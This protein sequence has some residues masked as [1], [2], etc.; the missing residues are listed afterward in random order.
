M[1]KIEELQLFHW[2][3]LPPTA[4]ELPSDQITVATGPN[5]S[6]KTTFLDALKVILGVVDLKQPPSAYIYNGAGESTRRARRAIVKATFAN[7]VAT[8]GVRAFARGGPGCDQAD[9]VTALCEVT[10]SIRR[11]AVLPGHRALAADDDPIV[12]IDALLT[13]VASSAWRKRDEWQDLM[14]DAG[15]SRA[16]LGVITVEQG[17]TARILEGS[18]AQLLRALLELTGK[19]ETADEFNETSRKLTQAMAD[20]ESAAAECDAQR[21]KLERLE[22]ACER[23]ALYLA[24]E[25]RRRDLEERWLPAARRVEAEEARAAAL[26]ARDQ[27]LAVAHDA[28]QRRAEIDDRKGPLVARQEDLR[29]AAE[30]VTAAV[31]ERRDAFGERSGAGREAQFRVRQLDER[32]AAARDALSGR[33]PV[34]ADADGATHDEETARH[35]AQVLSER[36]EQLTAEAEALRAGQIPM[37]PDVAAFAAAVREATGEASMLV[38]EA[39]DETEDLFVEAALGEHLWT[40]AV[41]PAWHERVVALAVEHGFRRPVA[42]LDDGGRPEGVLASA[43]GGEPLAAYLEEI[44]LPRGRP[45]LGED[46]V[47]RAATWAVLRE[48]ERAVLGRAVRAAR[49]STVERELETVNAELGSAR[50]AVSAAAKKVVVLRDGVAAL[51]ELPEAEAV[52]AAAAAATEKA[53]AALDASIGDAT[54]HAESVAA[55]GAALKELA[56]ELV[57]ADADADRADKLVVGA[58]ERLTDAEAQL[59]AAAPPAG[60]A[61]APGELAAAIVYEQELQGVLRRLAAEGG[62]FA[63]EVRDPTLPAQAAAQAERLRR[64]ESLL[65]ARGE[66]VEAVQAGVERA[67]ELYDLQINQVIDR[68]A[69]RFREV[70][71]NANLDG[72]IENLPTAP[73]EPRAVDVRV[74]HVKGSERRSYRSREHSTGER[75]KIAILLLLAAMGLDRS[76]DLL[77]MDEQFAHL[78]SR[79]ID[80]VADVMV[81]LRDQVQFIL[82]TPTNAEARRLHWCEHQLVFHPRRSGA[83]YAPPVQLLTT[84]PADPQRLVEPT[85]LT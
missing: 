49:L 18:P 75:A 23:H 43:S 38:A 37:P 79:N 65:S 26:A 74:A 53:A 11:W 83:A 41:A 8:S 20:R 59:L 35:A 82:A 47:A 64:A 67:R 61:I 17:Q 13:E 30:H 58:R 72:V 14:R 19:Q 52:A 56:R 36:Q 3:A 51:G 12:A 48:P 68:L 6:G 50:T 40:V 57:T 32:V 33:D 71:A 42:R 80:D 54:A 15:V 60:E 31:Q 1:P 27:A 24:D 2:G 73:D 70:C 44:D 81:A 85:L 84:Q 45:G 16:L 69:R 55:V 25:T 7:P 66:D 29:S 76:A 34:A 28:S 78:D 9:H 4:V 77:I 62:D 10:P 46:G 63:E 21:V 22:L 5:G 39:L